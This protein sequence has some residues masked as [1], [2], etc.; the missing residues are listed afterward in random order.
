[1]SHVKQTAR[2]KRGMVLPASSSE[3]EASIGWVPE[4]GELEIQS[5]RPAL[6]HSSPGSVQA[7]EAD[8]IIP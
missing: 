5:A 8:Q 3:M 1:M 6:E 4:D 7:E 2:L